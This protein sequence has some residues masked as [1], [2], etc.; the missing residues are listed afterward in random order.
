MVFDNAKLGIIILIAILLFQVIAF[1]VSKHRK[2]QNISVE[3]KKAIAKFAK[4]NDLLLNSYILAI[5]IAAIIRSKFGIALSHYIFILWTALLIGHNVKS[6]V[7]L[8]D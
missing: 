3:K 1:Y 2:N 5:I 8:R 7:D 6:Y 4:I